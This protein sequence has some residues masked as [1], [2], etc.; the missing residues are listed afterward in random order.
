MRWRFTV[1][2]VKAQAWLETAQQQT[3]NGPQWDEP[4][5]DNALPE[6]SA[7]WTACGRRD[8]V[9]ALVAAA[10]AAGV[11]VQPSGCEITFV[12]LPDPE[13]GDDGYTWLLYLT[14]GSESLR[15]CGAW[16]SVRR[17]EPARGA[18]GV[19]RALAMINDAANAGNVLLAQLEGFTQVWSWAS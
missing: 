3:R 10:Q 17:L 4:G 16:E 8:E 1:D 13:Y 15:V 6:I 12:Y 19:P 9:G 11:L 2:T 7:D 5:Y 18:P 14:A